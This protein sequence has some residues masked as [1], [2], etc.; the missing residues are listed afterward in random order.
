MIYGL[1]KRTLSESQ[2]A[3]HVA[4]QIGGIR[5]RGKFRGEVRSEGLKGKDR[6]DYKRL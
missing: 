6:V 5:N 1:K 2:N 4:V 3:G